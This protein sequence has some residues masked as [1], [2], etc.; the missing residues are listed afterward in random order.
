MALR[1]L[2]VCVLLSLVSFPLAARMQDRSPLDPPREAP[3]TVDVML[4][5]CVIET[6]EPGTFVLSGALSQPDNK[7]L[8]RMFRLVPGK[9]DADFVVH[10]NHQVH[11]SGRAEVTPV[12]D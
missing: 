10:V 3:A 8:P 9:K 6:P 11:T 1:A 4:T 5:G 12:P 2:A 7:D